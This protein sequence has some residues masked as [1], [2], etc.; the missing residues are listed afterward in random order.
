M[1]SPKPMPPQNSKINSA[2]KNPDNDPTGPWSQAIFSPRLLQLRSIPD[3]GPKGVG[4]ISGPPGPEILAR[5]RKRTA[6]EW[7]P[8]Q[9]IWWGKSGE[10]SHNQTFLSEVKQGCSPDLL[11][12]TKK[13][14]IPQEAKQEMLALFGKDVFITPKPE[15]LIQ[16]II[17]IASAEDDIVL[18]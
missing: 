7:I 12:D 18:G 3:N 11:V 9:R 17:Q 14:D 5:Y 15:R 10:S 8:R 4:V 2:Y 16:R 6:R 13:L 1:G